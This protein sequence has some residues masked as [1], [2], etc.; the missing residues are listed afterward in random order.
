MSG[1]CGG[2]NLSLKTH[3]C[4]QIAFADA[5]RYFLR[6]SLI[7]ATCEP[8]GG[9]LRADFDGAKLHFVKRDYVR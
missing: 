8:S 1:E 2:G 3:G 6:N 7:Y 4:A 9:A 5:R